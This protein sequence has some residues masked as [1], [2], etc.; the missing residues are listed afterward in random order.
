MF[1]QLITLVKGRSEDVTQT[2]VDA[3]AMTILRQQ[4]REAAEGV[5][6]SRKALAIVMA[7]NDREKS[8]LQKLTTQIVDLEARAMDALAQNKNDLA[9]EAAEAIASLEA[10]A[11]ATETTITTYS[12]EIAR[13]RK[14][15]KDSELQLAELKRGQRLAQANEKAINLHSA[16]PVTA[17]NNLQDASETLKSLQE[18]QLHARAT[19]D[20]ITE[21]STEANADTI[22]DRLAAAGC[23]TPKVNDA[24]AV[25]E[26][27]KAAQN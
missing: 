11:K 1:K 19:A 25:L 18:R 15:L 5:K 10:E 17:K 23:G 13:L 9:L 20:A 21:L 12:T 8:N 6:S 7:Y 3:N 22:S 16:M 4:L 24:S 27:L 14:T 26:R 2:I